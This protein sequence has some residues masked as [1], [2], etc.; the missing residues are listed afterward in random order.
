MRKG[1][2]SDISSIISRVS[3]AWCSTW[4]SSVRR[5]RAAAGNERARA[6]LN[7]PPSTPV[8]RLAP[9]LCALAN[10]PPRFDSV[11]PACPSSAAR[12]PPSLCS[13]H[14]EST[15][16]SRSKSRIGSL[17]LSQSQGPK[18]KRCLF[19]FSA[20]VPHLEAGVA[21]LQQLRGVC[22]CGVDCGSAGSDSGERGK[23]E[24]HLKIGPQKVR[25]QRKR[26]TRRVH[27]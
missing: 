5:A 7:S 11:G 18:T 19:Q 22:V 25:K 27:I 13:A 8:A 10:P 21:A 9:L 4:S 1:L 23:P 17:S 26:Q 6:R 3:A 14:S 20:A 16:Q 24:H 12:S 15:R 2:W